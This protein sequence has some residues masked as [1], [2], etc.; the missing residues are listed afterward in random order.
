MPPKTRS[1]GGV[2][3]DG[4]PKGITAYQFGIVSER[5]ALQ[6]DENRLYNW[7]L[8]SAFATVM[9]LPFFDLEYRGIAMKYMQIAESARFSSK[10]FSLLDFCG[11]AL[12]CYNYRKAVE[13]GIKDGDE[14]LSYLHSTPLSHYAIGIVTCLYS[15]FG[16]TTMTAIFLGE[17]ASWTA[18]DHVWGAFL[19]AWWLTFS[20]PFDV[21][22][23]MMESAALRGPLQAFACVS[24]AHAVTSWGLEKAL[25]ASHARMA[26]S[27]WAAIVCGYLSGCF[28]W[29]VV[30]FFE[31]M[32][33]R[34]KTMG[35]SWT[36]QRTFYAVIFYY[37]A[38]NPHGKLTP[39][40]ELVGL[41]DTSKELAQAI[42]AACFLTLQFGI[43]VVG[44]DLLKLIKPI[45][46]VISR[47]VAPIN[48]QLARIKDE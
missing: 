46:F 11:S 6:N 30:G 32:G 10:W 36:M 26:N 5:A 1:K 37:A 16:G 3:K 40:K 39:L 28:G 44:I 38:T 34:V 24:A 29:V 35:P 7:L 25:K 42:L 2:G 18:G 20:S 47:I 23:T 45:M 27:A 17:N 4:A 41:E 8:L 13:K 33:D 22:Y 12:V 48:M 19:L 31:T 14:R 9:F 43:D 15:Q 21:W